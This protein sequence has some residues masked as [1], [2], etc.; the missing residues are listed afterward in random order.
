MFETIHS[1][2]IGFYDNAK[3]AWSESITACAIILHVVLA[4][5]TV[6]AEHMSSKVAI[7]VLV[8]CHATPFC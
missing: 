4:S 5:A 8:D 6:L 7:T 1:S 2:Q 3:L